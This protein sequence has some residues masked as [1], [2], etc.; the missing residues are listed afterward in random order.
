MVFHS[1]QERQCRA[2]IRRYF[3]DDEALSFHLPAVGGGLVNDFCCFFCFL[4]SRSSSCSA[5]L[6]RLA[7][8]RSMAF[9]WIFLMTS[10][11]EMSRSRYALFK[12]SLWFR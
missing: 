5:R 8:F 11:M 2:R 10:L 6:R 1:R 3:L 4:V 7:C 9:L 12:M